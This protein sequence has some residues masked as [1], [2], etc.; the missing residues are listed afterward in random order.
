MSLTTITLEQV[1]ANSGPAV[2][3][4]Y[5]ILGK[6]LSA[7]AGAVGIKNA[8]D[9]E[10]ISDYE[11]RNRLNLD[12][13]DVVYWPSYLSR[14]I[15]QGAGGKARVANFIRNRASF[16]I[17]ETE[18]LCY[19]N[20]NLNRKITNH[21]GRLGLP[22]TYEWAYETNDYLARPGKLNIN[23]F[24]RQ[25]DT[26]MTNRD[27]NFIRYVFRE[28]QEQGFAYTSAMFIPTPIISDE[29]GLQL[30][31]DSWDTLK[32]IFF[33]PNLTVASRIKRKCPLG[34]CLPIVDDFLS[35]PTGRFDDCIDLLDRKL[36]DLAPE[37]IL[38][39]PLDTLNYVSGMIAK[40]RKFVDVIVDYGKD[41]EKPVGI[42]DSDKYYDLAMLTGTNIGGFRFDGKDRSPQGGSGAGGLQIE[43]WKVN[44]PDEH[45]FVQYQDMVA[46]GPNFRYLPQTTAIMRNQQLRYLSVAEGISNNVYEIA[47]AIING[48]LRTY[49]N[50]VL[51]TA[52][53]QVA[54]EFLGIP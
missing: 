24:Y 46:N 45:Q 31:L 23:R 44:S 18:W 32:N 27:P 36:P 43:R 17:P 54:H 47:D 41:N 16:A 51:Q 50:R 15:M 21:V 5:R 10:L 7:P 37:I 29:V 38:V 12:K 49:E 34:L 26:W 11:A 28:L 22:N 39:R 35:Q 13:V 6:I 48:T 1:H 52:V 25:F 8:N 40:F 30:G 53:S 33:G 14:F 42:I 9:L 19:R 20:R 3:C 4:D 2:T